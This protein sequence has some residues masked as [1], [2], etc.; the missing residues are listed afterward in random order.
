MSDNARALV[1]DGR[2]PRHRGLHKP[3]ESALRC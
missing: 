2:L 1:P 3:A